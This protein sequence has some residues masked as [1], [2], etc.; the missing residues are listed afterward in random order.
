MVHLPFAQ[1]SATSVGQVFKVVTCE[2]CSGQYVYLLKRKA[3]GFATGFH[4]LD[5]TGAGDVAVR[6]AEAELRRT[7]E[8]DRESVPCPSCGWY[9]A[10]MVA[11]LRKDHYCGMFLVGVL[12]LYGAVLMGVIGLVS[13]WSRAAELVKSSGSFIECAASLAAVGWSLILIRKLLATRV[14]PNNIDAEERKDL[15]RR[16]A[17]TK[18]AF[19]RLTAPAS[20]TTDPATEQQL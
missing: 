12:S 20:T 2:H 5:F 14:R 1:Y 13:R 16:L 18:A 19:D 6:E 3:D 15:G 10:D 9:Q 17:V 4:F 7:L 11:R 8:R